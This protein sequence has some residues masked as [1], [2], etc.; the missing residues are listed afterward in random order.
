MFVPLSWCSRL[1]KL[2]DS[3]FLSSREKARLRQ[4][5]RPS[6]TVLGSLD[7]DVD[8]LDV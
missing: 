5:P 7:C 1:D 2:V 3:L 4:E 6:E 8:S